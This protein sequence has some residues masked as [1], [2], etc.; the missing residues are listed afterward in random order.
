V[1]PNVHWQFT[2]RG[3]RHVTGTVRSEKSDVKRKQS[4]T[5]PV[6]PKVAT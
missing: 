5:A 3:H 1:L 2:N 4:A 6:R